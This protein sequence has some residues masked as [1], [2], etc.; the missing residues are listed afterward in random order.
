MQCFKKSVSQAVKDG[1]H[2]QLLDFYEDDKVLASV[3]RKEDDKEEEEYDDDDDE[4]GEGDFLLPLRRPD[5]CPDLT[6]VE[7]PACSPSILRP[8]SP[9]S[10]DGGSE[11]SSGR[12]REVEELEMLLRNS[13]AAD[14][15]TSASS[16]ACSSRKVSRQSSHKGQ[17]EEY[18]KG[19]GEE[20]EEEEEEERPLLWRERP[21]TS[22]QNRQPPSLPPIKV[23]DPG[24]RPLS[25]DVATST[26]L[27][28]FLIERCSLNFRLANYFYW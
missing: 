3:S 5:S 18:E 25:T 9:A 12:P 23:S 17:E 14:L 10:S 24:G 16:S 28:S 27:G 13:S 1:L 6:A 8:V 21:T 11:R 7:A 15:T 2:V 4:K 20:T 19:G 22:Q 26:D